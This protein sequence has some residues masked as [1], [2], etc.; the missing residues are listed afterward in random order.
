MAFV[1]TRTVEKQNLYAVANIYLSPVDAKRSKTSGLSWNHGGMA[2]TGHPLNQQ[3][4]AA[5]I[6]LWKLS[7]CRRARLT[8][9]AAVD[10]SSAKNGL[11]PIGSA[12][13]LRVNIPARVVAD[14]L[15]AEKIGRAAMGVTVSIGAQVGCPTGRGWTLGLIL[16][17]AGAFYCFRLVLLPRS[18][19][20]IVSAQKPQVGGPCLCIVQSPFSTFSNPDHKVGQVIPFTPISRQR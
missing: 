6:G 7:V 17:K 13:Q 11:A 8:A 20:R 19:Q 15:K 3:L 16:R 18:R 9:I 10:R 2:I 1:R 4:Y 12:I 5:S 14:L